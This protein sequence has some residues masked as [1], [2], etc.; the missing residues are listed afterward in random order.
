MKRKYFI[1]DGSV[2]KGPYTFQELSSVKFSAEDFVWFDGMD[3]WK[4]AR[5]LQEFK[6]LYLNQQGLNYKE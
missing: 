6:E 5:D 4:R 3:K 1:H 2:Q